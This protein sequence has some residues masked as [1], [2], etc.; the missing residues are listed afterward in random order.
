MNTWVSIGYCLSSISFALI[1]YQIKRGLFSSQLFSLRR[2][3]LAVS[4]IWRLGWGPFAVWKLV[5]K[6]KGHGAGMKATSLSNSLL[7]TACFGG[8]KSSLRTVRIPSVT[9]SM[10][11]PLMQAGLWDPY[12]SHYVPLLQ[13]FY[14]P[15]LP[16]R[17]ISMSFQVDKSYSNHGSYVKSMFG[18][19]YMH[20][21]HYK[22]KCGFSLNLVTVL[23]PFLNYNSYL[24]LV[25][26]IPAFKYI[27]NLW[28]YKGIVEKENI[29]LLLESFENLKHWV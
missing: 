12:S 28:S 14:L 29:F 10:L 18:I 3:R 6:W 23:N 20:I 24:I 8:N 5:E 17:Q 16:H 13:S 19:Q 7:L 4:C 25:W 21:C 11:S 22:F 15:M 1:E 9:S 2:S 26:E 27:S